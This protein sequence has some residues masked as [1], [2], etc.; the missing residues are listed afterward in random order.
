MRNKLVHDFDYHDE[1]FLQ[2]ISKTYQ[3]EIEKLLHNLK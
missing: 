2:E 3:K 1:S